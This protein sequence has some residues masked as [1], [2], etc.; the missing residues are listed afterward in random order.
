[1]TPETSA[2]SAEVRPRLDQASAVLA[3]AL[4][5]EVDPVEAMASAVLLIDSAMRH[6]AI[7]EQ[8]REILGLAS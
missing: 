2:L 1:V 4:L 7:E 6:V 5:G 8:R 3:R